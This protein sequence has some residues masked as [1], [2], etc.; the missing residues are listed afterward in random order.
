[1]LNLFN[2]D[3]LKSLLVKFPRFKFKEEFY[4]VSLGCL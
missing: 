4:C 3:I 2:S 1:M